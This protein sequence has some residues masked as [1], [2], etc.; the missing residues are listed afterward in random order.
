MD[1]NAHKWTATNRNRQ[2]RKETDQNGQKRTKLTETDKN[3][4]KDTETD[5][6]EQKYTE[7]GDKNIAGQKGTKTRETRRR[8]FFCP[9]T[10]DTESFD[11]CG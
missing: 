6:N 4:K 5:R 2:K 3:E 8:L 1:R 7:M 10:G 9:H 11:R